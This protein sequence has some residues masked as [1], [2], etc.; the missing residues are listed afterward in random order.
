MKKF[1]NIIT[2][3]FVTIIV[4]FCNPVNAQVKEAPAN[5]IAAL[6][7]KLAGF[8]K[9]ISGNAGDITIY[10][11]GAA[12]VANELKK[13]IG[14]QIGNAT[15]KSVETGNNL[16]TNK[17]AILHVGDA[18]K[19]QEAI[20]YTRSNKIL[21]TTGQPNLVTDGVTLGIGVGEDG[22]PKILLN[23][24]SSVEEGLDWNP[25]IMKVAKTIK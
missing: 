18:S 9:N 24:T 14:K 6:I 1:K 15:L 10:V 2:A 25:A 7:V 3:F 4:L 23:L 11:L 5:V 12:D 21:S 16:P 13:G 8:E 17:P 22:K 20:Q 19:A